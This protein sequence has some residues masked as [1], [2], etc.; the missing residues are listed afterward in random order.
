M[1]QRNVPKTAS[2]KLTLHR[3]TLRS[4]N[5]DELKAVAGAGMHI[6]R[7]CSN[8]TCTAECSWMSTIQTTIP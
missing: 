2:R 3:E 4:L 8:A 5:V 6:S 7:D 1:E